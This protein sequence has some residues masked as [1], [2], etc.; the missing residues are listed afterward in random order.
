M[1][2]IFDSL[3]RLSGWPRRAALAGLGALA[4]LALPP[5]YV[6]PALLPA[7]AGFMLLLNKMGCRKGA[8]A[9][10]WWFGFGFFTLGLYWISNAL[11]IDAARFAWFIP[12]SLFGLSALL[13]VFTGLASLLS[14]HVCRQGFGAALS[15]S[16]CWALHEWLRSFILTGFPWNP[17]ASVWTISD[18]LLQADAWLGPYGLG[19]LTV[20]AASAWIL[21]WSQKVKWRW[22]AFAPLLVLA[23]LGVAGMARLQEAENGVVEDVRLRLVQPNI[24]QSLKWKQELR[25]SHLVKLIEMSLSETARPPTHVIWAETAVPYLLD[26]DV[27]ARLAV[28]KAAPE[29]GLVIT[30]A[31]RTSTDPA[32]PFQVWNSLMALDRNGAVRGVFDKFHLVPFGEYMP[33]KNILPLKKITEGSTDF[34]PGP[35]PLTIDLPGLPPVG[36]LICYEVIFPGAVADADRRPD[37]LLNLTNDSWY[38]F[39][40]GPFQ[41]FAQTRM[42]AVEEG[43]P[44][45]RVANSGVS[46]IIDAHGRVRGK[47]DLNQVGILDADLPKSL[48]ARP[49]YATLG[50]GPYISG[51]IILLII[52]KFMLCHT[53]ISTVQRRGS[54]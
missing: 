34:S 29:S 41:H 5:L 44:L 8:F 16:A 54:G 10:G 7:F 26:S 25:F 45:V 31:V 30:G 20:L 27:Q 2:K 13:A 11:L 32:Q 50:D 6:L 17:I 42:R 3:L 15:L 51:L 47:L 39:S 28:A 21:F 52:L 9:A 38:G 49:T 43:L 24:E 23:L 19:F 14:W 35:G 48:P 36:P 53:K 33:L 46:G 12:F 22:A 4:A 37:W 18:P 1:K 40:T